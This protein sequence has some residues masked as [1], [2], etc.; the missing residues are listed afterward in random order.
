VCHKL[1][2]DSNNQS[3]EVSGDLYNCVN[4]FYFSMEKSV[5]L[6]VARS[7]VCKVLEPVLTPDCLFSVTIFVV[8]FYLS[9]IVLIVTSACAEHSVAWPRFQC[10][11]LSLD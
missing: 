1:I 9:A 7:L 11:S 8:D 5:F 6:G 4:L 10:R 3:R 2:L